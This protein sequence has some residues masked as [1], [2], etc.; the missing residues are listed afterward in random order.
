MEEPWTRLTGCPIRPSFPGGVTTRVGLGARSCTGTF[1]TVPS[2]RRSPEVCLEPRQTRLRLNSGVGLL[3]TLIFFCSEKRDL[4]N[5]ETKIKVRSLLLIVTDFSNIWCLYSVS[6]PTMCVH[7]EWS[8]R[9]WKKSKSTLVRF[10]VV[11]TTSG[12]Y[13]RVLTRTFTNVTEERPLRTE[14]KVSMEDGP[15]RDVG[16]CPIPHTTLPTTWSHQS[17]SFRPGRDD[18]SSLREVRD[19][20]QVI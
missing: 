14:S 15:S 1:V 11:G 10:P 17:S 2:R 4:W 13:R 18:E 19:R 5:F 20:W 16:R 8:R 6:T 9:N 12:R 3:K 7:S